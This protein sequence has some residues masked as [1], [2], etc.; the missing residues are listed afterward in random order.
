MASL[1]R[2]YTLFKKNLLNW[3]SPNQAHLNFSDKWRRHSF[4]KIIN[5][6]VGVQNLDNLHIWMRVLFQCDAGF[7]YITE[8]LQ[9]RKWMKYLNG[10]QF[11]ACAGDL[12][13]VLVGGLVD[14]QQ[15][16]G[17][18][19]R[20]QSVHRIRALQLLLLQPFLQVTDVTPTQTEKLWNNI[21]FVFSFRHLMALL[22]PLKIDRLLVEL[23]PIS[24]LVQGASF[25]ARW[26][27]WHP[28]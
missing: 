17:L 12:L 9:V 3:K 7:C 10:V 11:S 25:Y 21:F 16:G 1:W 13:G 14:L 2:H 26:A 6:G 20:L 5:G 18:R 28:L 22:V 27:T 4:L 23:K 15:P 19:Q 24:V 8:I